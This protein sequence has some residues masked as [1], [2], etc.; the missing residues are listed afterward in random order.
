MFKR[1]NFL[2]GKLRLPYHRRTGPAERLKRARPEA[3]LSRNKFKHGLTE[4][5]CF[6]CDST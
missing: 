1:T 5:L 3:Q 2:T 6:V 4:W